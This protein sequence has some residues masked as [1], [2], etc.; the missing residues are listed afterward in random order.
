MAI[1]ARVP[2]SKYANILAPSGLQA[3]VCADVVALGKV[4][5]TFGGEKKNK[6]MVRLVF[7]LAEAIPLGTFIHPCTGDEVDVPEE[8]GGRQFDV[9]RRFNLSL[10]EKAALRSFVRSWRGWDFTQDELE[11]FDLEELIGVPA[12]LSI[13]HVQSDSDGRWYANI[14]SASRLPEQWTAPEIPVGYLRAKDREYK[15]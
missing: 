14:D 10:H 1:M 15:G 12:A 11:G 7:L 5:S 13:V 6:E 8:L 4:E 3:A 9:S 2:E